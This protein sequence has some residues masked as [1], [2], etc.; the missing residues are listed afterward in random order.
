[1]QPRLVCGSYSMR[2]RDLQ[3]RTQDNSVELSYDEAI[4]QGRDH[5]AIPIEVIG[6]LPALLRDGMKMLNTEH[7]QGVFLTTALGVL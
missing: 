2:S 1:M 5:D 6:A 3:Y 7:E 4:A